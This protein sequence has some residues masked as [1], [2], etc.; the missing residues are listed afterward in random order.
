M[1][2][3]ADLQKIIATESFYEILGVERDADDAVI[4]KAYRKV[5]PVHAGLSPSPRLQTA[6]C[7]ACHGGCGGV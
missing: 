1:A 3:E 7:K 6:W 4:K 2:T 5:S